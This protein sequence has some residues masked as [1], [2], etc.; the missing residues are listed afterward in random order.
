[1]WVAKAAPAVQC[2]AAL[3]GARLAVAHRQP[4]NSG[5]EGSITGKTRGPAPRIL[6]RQH[7]GPSEQIRLACG[8]AA[9][10]AERGCCT[11]IA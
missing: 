9:G 5:V 11:M 10:S 7:I 4:R 2:C 1:V 6:D 8:A 3:R